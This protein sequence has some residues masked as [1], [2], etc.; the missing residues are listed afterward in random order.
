MQKE[1]SYPALVSLGSHDLRTPLATIH[2]FVKT[3]ER[4]A[5]LAPP[6]DRYVQMIAEAA[7]QMKELL[8]ELSLATRI[9]DGR[10][11][12][13]LRETDT[14]ALARAAQERLGADHV[15]VSGEGASVV[16]DVEAVERAVYALIRATRRHGGLDEVNV[17]VRGPR[18]EVSP[19]TEASSHVVLGQDLRDFGA[20]VAVRAVETLGGTVSVDAGTLRINLA[21]DRTPT[22]RADGG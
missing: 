18:I 7:E 6:S 21:S 14:L 4:T 19:V 12:P 9:E 5:E 13:V 15:R 22:V 11:Q 17:V 16:A 1:S 10:Y 20:A 2:G 3:L 8:D